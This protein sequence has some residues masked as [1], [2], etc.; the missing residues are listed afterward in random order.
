MLVRANIPESVE[1]FRDAVDIAVTVYFD[2]RAYD[3]DNIPAKIM[4]D[5]LIG[6]VIVNDTWRHVRSV[7]TMSRIDKHRPRLEIEIKIA[8]PE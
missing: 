8:P 4:I 5:G 3:A 6:S 2:K 1:T 7:T